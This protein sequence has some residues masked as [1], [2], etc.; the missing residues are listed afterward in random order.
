MSDSIGSNSSESHSQPVV[1]IVV[2]H[3]QGLEYTRACLESLKKLHYQNFRVL[4][5]D[6]CS[7]DSSGDPLAAEFPQFEY[8]KS[9][10]NLGFAGGCNAAV[11]QCAERG[12]Q[13]IWLLN[14]D[15]SVHPDSL[16]QLILCAERNPKAALLGGQVFTPKG[17]SFVASGGG[18]IDFAKGKTYERQEAPADGSEIP[19]DWIS[20]CNLLL[21]LEAFDS[22]GGFDESFFLYFE[23][24]DLCYRARQA[25]WQCMLV[26]AA[27]VEHIGLRSSQGKQSTWRHYYYIRN[28]LLFFRR[29]AQDSRKLP[30]TLA[31]TAH[32]A[33]H[34]IT[35]PFRGDEGRRRLKAEILGY[36][37]YWRQKLG[38]ADCLDW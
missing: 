7:P 10:Q 15:T 24:T 9:A 17:E 38:K 12:A 33:R 22:L 4:I 6:N 28:R 8:V 14:N 19:C 37:D 34:S 32:V 2:L 18:Q 36:T 13:W 29:H 26:P 1:W 27:R 21:R 35:L 20:G 3:Y 25:G 23:D 31:I 30:I 16:E 11:R 5:F